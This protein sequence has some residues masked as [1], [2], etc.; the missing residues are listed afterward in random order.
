MG[1]ILKEENFIR[2]AAFD[3]FDILYHFKSLRVR[4]HYFYCFIFQ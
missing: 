2:F 4:L 3:G 1:T